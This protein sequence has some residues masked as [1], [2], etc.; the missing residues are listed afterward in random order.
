MKNLYAIAL[1]LFLSTFVFAQKDV[2]LKMTHLLGSSPYLKN[3]TFQTQ[4][5]YSANITRLQ[6]YLSGI[7]IIHDGGKIT[8]VKKTWFLIDPEKDHTFPLGTHNVTNIEGIKFSIGVEKQSNHLDPST[9]P[10]NHPLAHQNPIMHWGWASGYRFIALEGKAGVNKG[11]SYQIHSL[12]DKNYKETTVTTPAKTVGSKLVIEIEADYIQMFVNIDASTG[13]IEHG[14]DNEAA[15]LA[16]NMPGVFKPKGSTSVKNHYNNNQISVSPN[17]STDG[18][19]NL[20]YNTPSED[21]SLII[22]DITGKK[23]TQIKPTW[24]IDKIDLSQQGKGIYFMRVLNNETV[25][26]TQKILIQ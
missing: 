4:G 6:Y 11:T 3:T 5:N 25:L 21:I 19:F 20:T 14:E 1:S 12:G 7:K 10:S 23:V 22:F 2:E 24:G 16:S 8:E 15:T 9:Y 26:S 13:V 18:V 17:P